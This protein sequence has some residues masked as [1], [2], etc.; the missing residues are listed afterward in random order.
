[1]SKRLTLDVDRCGRTGGLQVSINVK[2]GDRGHG[3]RLAGPK[4]LGQS[5]PVLS[6]AL[7]ERDAEQVR[8]L[9]AEVFE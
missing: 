2:D 4:Y 3:Y 8:G 7:S 9:I 1:M 6:V 5:T